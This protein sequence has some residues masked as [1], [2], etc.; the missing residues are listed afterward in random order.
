LLIRGCFFSYVQ[1][2]TR[3]I[4][5]Q[6]VIIYLNEVILKQTRVFDQIFSQIEEIPSSLVEIFENLRLGCRSVS[7]GFSE[8]VYSFVMYNS[9]EHLDTFNFVVKNVVLGTPVDD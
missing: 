2:E 7:P 4:V 6:E 8:K 9:V 1:I 5:R 3:P